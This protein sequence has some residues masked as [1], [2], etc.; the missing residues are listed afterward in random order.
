MLYLVYVT[1]DFEQLGLYPVMLGPL[2]AEPNDGKLRQRCL[3]PILNSK[4]AQLTCLSDKIRDYSNDV[5]HEVDKVDRG[6]GL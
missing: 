6:V 2:L 5:E 3:I 1:H 4:L